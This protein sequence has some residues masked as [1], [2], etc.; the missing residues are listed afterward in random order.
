M[1]DLAASGDAGRDAPLPDAPASPDET[2][3]GDGFIDP[4]RS[5]SEVDAVK[6]AGSAPTSDVVGHS[7]GAGRPTTDSG[8]HMALQITPDGQRLY[9]QFVERRERFFAPDFVDHDPAEGQ[10]GGGEGLAWFW[11]TFAESF[12]DIGRET[13]EMVVTADHVITVMDLS[14]RH[15]GDFM[16]YAATGR[17]FKVRNIQVAKFENGRMT[18][19]WGSTDQLGILQQLGLVQA[20]D[21]HP[22][23]ADA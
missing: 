10:P 11:E 8:A 15:T 14:G 9:E 20:S 16:G 7:V 19:R 2:V 5:A 21:T 18:E 23:T 6:T 12:T 4:L 13:V 3:P 22:R 17:R 1:T